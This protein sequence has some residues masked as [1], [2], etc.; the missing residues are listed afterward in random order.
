M[1]G[2]ENDDLDLEMAMTD[3]EQQSLEAAKASKTWRALRTAT[4]TSIEVLDKVEPGKSLIQVFKQQEAAED[5]G[6]T[7]A[8]DIG[9]EEVVTS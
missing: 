7:S 4:R 2:I 3:E 9:K 6:E 1:K 5:G 8:A